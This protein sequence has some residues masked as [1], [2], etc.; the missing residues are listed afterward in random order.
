MPAGEAKDV[1]AYLLVAPELA[2]IAPGDGIP[3]AGGLS[4]CRRERVR[5]KADAY[6]HT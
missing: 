4:V 3:A 1:C 2:I 5:G 6:Q